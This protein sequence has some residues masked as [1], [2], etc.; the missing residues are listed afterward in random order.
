MLL[1]SVFLARLPYRGVRHDA[2]LYTA[3]ALAHLN[4]AWTV[5]DLYFEY[6]SQDRFT[7]FS[8]LLAWPIAHFGI[9]ASEMGVMVAG[10]ALYALALYRLVAHFEPNRR[11]LAL[12]AVACMIHF[13]GGRAFS[14]LEPFATARSLAEPCVLMGLADVLVC[15]RIG[16][17]AWLAL[18]LAF[19]PLMAIPGVLV[20]WVW[21]ARQDRRW[22]WAIASV[23]PVLALA[24]AG[25]RPFDGLLKRLDAEWMWV[26]VHIND[27]VFLSAWTLHD[28]TTAAMDATLLWLA[29]R[30]RTGT[31][32]EFSRTLLAT[33]VVITLACL[34]LGDGLHN[35]LITQLQIWRVM[36][37]VHL[38]AMLWLPS[39]VLDEWRR[40]GMGRLCA[41]TILCVVPAVQAW[42]QFAW[43]LVLWMWVVMAMS[44]LEVKLDARLSRWAM[45]GMLG[46]AVVSCVD[47][48]MTLQY[49]LGL[50]ERGLAISY[51]A[52]LPFEL[53]Q[54]TVP[55]VLTLMLAWQRGGHWR[56]WVA[57]FSVVAF[58]LAI[59]QYDQ[60]TPF[61]RYIESSQASEQP[62]SRLIPQT[63]TV[64]WEGLELAPVWLMLRRAGF[65]QLGQFSGVVFNRDTAMAARD[66]LPL[67][68]PIAAVN[69]K[70]G[71]L[72]G[73]MPKGY[74]FQDCE[75]PAQ[76][77]F[78]FCTNP[79]LH[80]DYLV[81]SQRYSRPPTASWTFKPD[82]GQ[83]PVTYYLHD[84]RTVH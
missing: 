25:V 14:I 26:I 63:A 21:L 5:R 80:A 51:S 55:V 69:T 31:L 1:V 30:K 82:D 17:A 61:S 78:R 52:S 47:T 9:H 28:A 12:T 53:P 18:A 38:F 65:S 16:A 7:I 4:P 42:T 10:Y 54:V 29:T 41:V 71:A 19:H 75:V 8:R 6:G 81:T 46:A 83:E 56:T 74:V 34:V 37:L 36:W 70:C 68:V 39:L 35:V 64:Y 79:G 77:F 43:A 66:R 33:G 40:T 44:A 57:G 27:L 45:L 84:C 67:I 32:A 22:W 58:V 23:V 11:W 59:F 13:Y 62:F 76:D 72:R 24:L 2:L 3:Q 48:V 20:A 50:P 15:R 49:Q 60:R 73:W